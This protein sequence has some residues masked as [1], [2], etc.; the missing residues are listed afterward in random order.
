MFQI[1]SLSSHFKNLEQRIAKYNNKNKE[2]NKKIIKRR[3]Q[4]N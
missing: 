3:K 1:N 4:R 2:E